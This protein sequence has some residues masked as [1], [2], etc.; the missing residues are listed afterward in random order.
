[1]K[2][3]E[4]RLTRVESNHNR[5]RTDSVEGMTSELPVVGKSFCLIGESLTEGMNA[6]LVTTSKITKVDQNGDE[7]TFNTLNSTY[8]I[9]VLG[10]EIAE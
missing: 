8:K 4:V 5:I 1:M 7:Y 10:T 9:E 6:R 2:V 3:Y